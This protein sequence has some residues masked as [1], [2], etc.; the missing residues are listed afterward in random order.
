M[1]AEA[2]AATVSC[3]ELA[4]ILMQAYGPQYRNASTARPTCRDAQQVLPAY[5][6]NVA[7][8]LYFGFQQLDA[9]GAF[10]PEASVSRREAADALWRVAQLAWLA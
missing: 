8:T 9:G 5:A 3:Q 7:R 6:T 1:T 4:T 10:H 2:A